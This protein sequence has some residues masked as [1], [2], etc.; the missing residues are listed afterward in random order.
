MK[1]SF[2]VLTIIFSIAIVFT[3]VGCSNSNPVEKYKKPR[4][5]TIKNN[6]HK[7]TLT[8]DN[9]GAYAENKI[10][11]GEVVLINSD[12]KFRLDFMYGN[13]DIGEQKK[14]MKYSRDDDRLVLID[15]VKF[16]G[17]KGYVTIN[18]KYGTV[19]VYLYVHNKVV[20]INIS[21]TDTT[22]IL[23]ELKKEKP[24]KVLYK[25]EDVQNILKTIKYEK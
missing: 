19:D 13:Q 25:K 22:G 11:N 14:S 12:K 6:K 9:D 18:K 24:E 2:K 5:V 10:G 21:T 4:T 17:Y 1:K 3:V 15:H 23:E 20:N 7:V 16:N 8:Y